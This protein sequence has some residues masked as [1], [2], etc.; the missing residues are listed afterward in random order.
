MT[1]LQEEC[2]RHRRS[3][4]LRD[5]TRGTGK[6]VETVIQQHAQVNFFM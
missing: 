4:D 2:Y 6:T 1:Q 5:V 3:L